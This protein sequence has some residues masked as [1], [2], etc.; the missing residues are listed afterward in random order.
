[1]SHAFCNENDQ[2]NNFAPDLHLPV[3]HTMPMDDEQ[4][5]V[6]SDTAKSSKT[7]AFASLTEP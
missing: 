4:T 6:I 1:M 3:L 7:N 2:S 5:P